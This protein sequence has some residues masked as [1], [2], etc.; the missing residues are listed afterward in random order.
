SS[1]VLRVVGI[2]V[3]FVSSI[4]FARML[5]PDGY[6]RYV[7]VMALASIFALG[8]GL[9]LPQYLVREVARL[10][11]G[12]TMPWMLR[13][14]DSRVLLVGAIAAGALVAGGMLSNSPQGR[15]TFFAA[16]LIPLAAPLAE[17][18]GALL[19]SQGAIARSQWPT[20]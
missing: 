13:W 10:G 18:R 11:S 4:V 19:Q 14:A 2:G 9:G 16:A 17:I 12:P 1:A 3:V 15:A 6:G 20:L 8:A 7:F 5:G